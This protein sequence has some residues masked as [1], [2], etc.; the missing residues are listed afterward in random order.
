[1]ARIPKLDS[2]GKFL[3]ADVN[4]QIDARTKATMRADLPALA[5]ELK[6]GGGSGI[7]QVSGTIT[8]DSTGAP[9]RE[10]Y[11]TGA[12]T[13]KANGADT[14]VSSY[15]AV[16]WRRD[17]SGK[18]AYQAIQ[19]GWTTPA[20]TPDTTP[21]TPGTL[22]VSN[23][24]GTSAVLTVAGASD[25]Q[26]LDASPFR[27]SVDQGVTWSLWQSSPSFTATGLSGLKQYQAVAQV[28]DAA[29]LTATTPVQAFTTL[30][31]PVVPFTFPGA[32]GTPLTGMTYRGKQFGVATDP[33]TFFGSKAGLPAAADTPLALTG[34]NSAKG[35]G[36]SVIETGSANFEASV[37]L[38]NITKLANGDNVRL[39]LNFPAGGATAIFV[40]VL[41]YEGNIKFYA[42]G[43]QVGSTLPMNGATSGTISLKKQ[44]QT[45]TVTFAGQT[46][47][48][49]TLPTSA[50]IGTSFGLMGGHPD[51][52][53][54]NLL[55]QPL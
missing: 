50:V 52:T 20:A 31:E 8:L 49:T 10:F 5:K 4:A 44:G 48:T 39:G 33:F 36:Q 40:N 7:E 17:G 30:A 51:A 54:S 37:D 23:I 53:F 13:F 28:R 26:G 16:V 9:I 46:V 19:E 15:T 12:T 29:G 1:M 27:F 41:P 14:L 35:R 21:P 34:A 6:I 47:G 24:Q 38:A 45:I 25:S 18:W 2:A 22:S 32:A 43:A 3:A 42:N 11:T 55:I